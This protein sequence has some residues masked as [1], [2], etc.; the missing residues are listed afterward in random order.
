[1]N[2]TIFSCCEGKLVY[3]CMQV[4][5]YAG[6]QVFKYASMQACKYASMQECKNARM[7]VCK[8]ASVQA[9]IQV[10]EGLKKPGLFSDIDQ[11]GGWV[12][13]RNQYFLKP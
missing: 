9:S 6:M 4:C 11:K 8:Y 12:S 7:Q 3:A 2:H 1:M 10:R 13:C 5:K